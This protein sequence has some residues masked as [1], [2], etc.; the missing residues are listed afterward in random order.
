LLRAVGEHV[1]TDVRLGLV[2]ETAVVDVVEVLDGLV[3]VL[4]IDVLEAA[5]AAARV[6]DVLELLVVVVAA[7]AVVVGGTRVVVVSSVTCAAMAATACT[8][9][10]NPTPINSS[11]AAT[12]P[13]DRCARDGMASFLPSGRSAPGSERLRTNT[14]RRPVTLLGAWILPQ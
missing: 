10:I 8:G 14:P 2:A 3:V 6:L 7:A 9:P 1:G 12:I 4:L 5:G 13:S 11:T